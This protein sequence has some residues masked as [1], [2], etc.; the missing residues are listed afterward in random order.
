MSHRVF[1]L[2]L[3]A[4]A[5]LAAACGSGGDGPEAGGSA[6][7]SSICEHLEDLCGPVSP[8]CVE[9]CGSFSGQTRDC[10]ASADSCSGAQ[11]CLEGDGAGDGP[12]A[13]SGETSGPDAGDP[14]GGET[15]SNDYEVGVTTC[16]YRDGSDYVIGCQPGA[17]G[18][19]VAIEVKCGAE[20]YCQNVPEDELD[21][22]YTE[23]AACCEQ[24][25]DGTTSYAPRRCS[26]Q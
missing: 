8:T 15:C 19:P 13:G 9:E 11:S 12:D 16:T 23:Q 4:F 21:P 5:V 25:A 6:S 14:G 10:M 26:A 1:V 3:G 18:V 22:D 24:G 20:E 2:V 7:C 17:S